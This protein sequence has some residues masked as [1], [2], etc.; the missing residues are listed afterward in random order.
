MRGWAVLLL[1][2][3]GTSAQADRGLIPFDTDVKLFEPKQQALIAWNGQEEILILSTDVYA[4]KPTKVLQIFPAPSEPTFKAADPKVFE[5]ATNF[6]NA[7]YLK[8]G[9]HRGGPEAGATGGPSFRGRSG[10]PAGEVVRHETI[11]A[12]ELSLTR[13]IDANGFC[14]WAEEYLRSQGADAPRVNPLMR[15]AIEGYMAK[16]FEWFV[17]DVV[18]LG[19]NIKTN[20]PIQYRFKSDHL[21]YPLVLTK[22]SDKHVNIELLVITGRKLYEFPELPITK[23]IGNGF[24]RADIQLENEMCPLSGAQLRQL[25]GDIQELMAPQAEAILREWRL[26]PEY[27]SSFYHDLVAR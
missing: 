15:S 24:S 2:L 23:V 1:I 27:G 21:F 19:T 6:I 16:G 5:T 13:V 17:Y 25:S 14:D 26:M 4:S 20:E 11:G 12:H 10:R 22:T 7:H 9:L 8:L 3:V 18:E